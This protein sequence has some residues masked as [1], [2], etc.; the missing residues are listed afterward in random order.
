M[1]V[2][3]SAAKGL[4]RKPCGGGDRCTRSSVHSER[5]EQW[6]GHEAC[7]DDKERWR[8]LARL[9]LA[10]SDPVCGDRARFRLEPTEKV[11]DR[12][13]TRL[14][15]HA[16]PPFLDH[17]SLLQPL[18]PNL[19]V[20]ADGDGHRLCDVLVGFLEPTPRRND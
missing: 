14:M 19:D 2:L 9:R 3:N 15:N 16:K 7:A 10:A 1:M 8:R 4:S 11:G 6:N 13:R 17:G 12:R 20:I 5:I 18:C